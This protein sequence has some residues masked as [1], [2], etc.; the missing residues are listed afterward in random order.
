MTQLELREATE[1]ARMLIADLVL[2]GDIASARWH[3]GEV[4]RMRDGLLTGAELEAA[5]RA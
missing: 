3:A 2:S 1:G 4:A 5:V